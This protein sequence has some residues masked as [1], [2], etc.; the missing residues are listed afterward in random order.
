[1]LRDV[2]SGEVTPRKTRK[3]IILAAENYIRLVILV[4][5]IT[6]LWLLS[7]SHKAEL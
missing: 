4:A 3:Y 1:M 6:V 5:G 2:E 7:N